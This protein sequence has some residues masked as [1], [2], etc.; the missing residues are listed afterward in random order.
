ME[1]TQ[2]HCDG[3]NSFLPN[4]HESQLSNNSP[5]EFAYCI[6]ATMENVK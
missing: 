6:F 5:S 1:H 2:T 4:G 3:P